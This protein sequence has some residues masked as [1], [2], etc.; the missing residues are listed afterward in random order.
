M[1]CSRIRLCGSRCGSPIAPTAW[2]CSGS[3][4]AARLP[5]EPRGRGI[6]LAR[7][8][9]RTVQLAIADPRTPH[10]SRPTSP[11][12]RAVRPAWCEPL[13]AHARA[14]LSA[15]GR[16]RSRVR[17]P[18]P[19][20]RATAAGRGAR[21][22]TARASAR[23]RRR[24]GGVVDRARD[25]RRV[26]GPGRHA[27]TARPA[28]AGGRLGGRRRGRRTST[29]SLP[30]SG[31][32]SSLDDL[33]AL[34]APVR[35]GL[36]P[37][38]PRSADRPGAKQRGRGP[39]AGG[40]RPSPDRSARGARRAVRARGS[41]CVRPR[42]KSTCSVAANRVASTPT[43]LP[44][45]APGAVRSFRSRGPRRPTGWRRPPGCRWRRR[46]RAGS[47]LPITR[48]R[49]RRRPAPCAPG[50][51]PRQ[52]RPGDRARGDDGPVARRTRGDT[53]QLPTCRARR[54]GGMA[55]RLGHA[56]H[57]ASRV[58]D[59]GHRCDRGRPP[60]PAA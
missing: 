60:C 48:S 47:H 35:P 13:P 55:R 24:R 31:R 41:C 2:R 30:V 15:S 33:D 45:R 10:A 18:R 6:L 19:A 7:G 11:R 43:F 8:E 9:P 22:G 53:G 28:R 23:H 27:R 36:P 52:R 46:R 54:S 39:A 16:E 25:A 51:T 4:A 40:R 34:V 57:R 14:R 21:P 17:T 38:I 49:G 42:E 50:E 56:G 12:P 1:R 20:R 3:D 59:R 44:A 26:G 37:R 5:A 58:A 29:G 32:S